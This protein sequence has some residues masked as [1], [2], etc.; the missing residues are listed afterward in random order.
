MNNKKARRLPRGVR[1][2]GDGRYLVYVTRRGKPVRLTVTWGLLAELRVP[3]PPTRLEH[4]G[5]E[6]A[7]KALTQLNAKILEEQRTGI[8]EATAR[9]RIGDLLELMEQDYLREG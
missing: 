3:V 2:L 8:I 4:P 7:K 9:T 6:L 5:L 1:Q